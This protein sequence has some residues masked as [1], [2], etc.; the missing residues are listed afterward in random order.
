MD[1]FDTLDDMIIRDLAMGDYVTWERVSNPYEPDLEVLLTFSG[2]WVK[3]KVPHACNAPASE[4][5]GIA[6]QENPKRRK[7]RSKGEQA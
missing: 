4:G 7:K 3:R 5:L 1:T 6:P 2:I